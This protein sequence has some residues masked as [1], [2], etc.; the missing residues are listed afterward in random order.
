MRQYMKF[1]DSTCFGHPPPSSQ[2]KMGNIHSLTP[3]QRSEKSPMFSNALTLI[4]PSNATTPLHNHPSPPET[5]PFLP[6]RQ[7]WRLRDFMCSIWESVCR[8]NQPQPQPQPT[9]RTLHKTQQTHNQ[10]TPSTSSN[11]STNIA[12]LIKQ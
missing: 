11:T 2:H 10:H 12:L 1:I 9:L 6:L 5:H 3:H 8:P 4:S 7:K